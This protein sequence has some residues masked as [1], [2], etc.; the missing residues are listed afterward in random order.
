MKSLNAYHKKHGTCKDYPE[1]SDEAAIKY[2]EQ[3]KNAFSWEKKPFPSYELTSVNQK[4]KS[5][6][7][8]IEEL[9][10]LDEMPAEIICFG[11]GEIEVDIDENRVKIRFDER[12]ADEMSNRLRKSGFNWS[13]LNKCWQ[14]LRS[15]DALYYAKK[16]CGI[17][18]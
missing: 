11:G 15:Y 9:K 1:I 8:R 16:I 6:E 18:V 17:E 3:I 5:A 4:I 12:T 7:K 10:R 14:R 2:D 13:P